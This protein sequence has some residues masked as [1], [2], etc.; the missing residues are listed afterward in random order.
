MPPWIV[1]LAA[2]LGARAAWVAWGPAP[3][4]V[5]AY[6]V[7]G[8]VLRLRRVAV[9]GLVVLDSPQIGVSRW[10]PLALK[11]LAPTG[12]PEGGPVTGWQAGIIS[13]AAVVLSPAMPPPNT[14]S[15]FSTGF[16]AAT[17]GQAFLFAEWTDS[18]GMPQTCDFVATV[19]G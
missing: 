2:A 5:R 11:A 9:G 15:Q 14:A 4:V 17:P 19:V 12:S 13:G 10:N 18:N 16:I 3:A 6:A 1:A 8:G 7:A